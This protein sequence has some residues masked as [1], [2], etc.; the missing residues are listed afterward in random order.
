MPEKELQSATFV[1]RERADYHGMELSDD[2][3]KDSPVVLFDEWLLSA[4]QSG[5][6][7][8]NAMTLCTSGADGFPDAR[9]VLLRNISYGGFTFFTNY[10]SK[11][12]DDLIYCRNACLHFFWK[13]LMRQV[14]IKGPIELLPAKESDD[15]FN[16]RPFENQVGAWASEQ[17]RVVADRKTLDSKFED[18]LKRFGNGHVPRP[19]HWG[20]YV[21]K[22]SC[23]EFWQGRPGRLHDRIEFTFDAKSKRWNSRRLMP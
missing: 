13:D 22:P 8:A 10:H 16:S 20:G 23:F 6:D 7:F 4:S 12:A 11:K 9:V 2:V 17:S 3:R 1:R 15:Y 18:T 5:D 19:E 21:L 14:K